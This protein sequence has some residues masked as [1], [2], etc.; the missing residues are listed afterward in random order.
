MAKFRTNIVH[1]NHFGVSDSSHDLA[2]VVI[3]VVLGKGQFFGCLARVF[4][5]GNN[6]GAGAVIFVRCTLVVIRRPSTLSMLL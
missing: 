1:Q 6:N 5:F 4:L 3:I 2:M